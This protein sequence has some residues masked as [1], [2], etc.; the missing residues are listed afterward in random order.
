[1][2]S[3]RLRHGSLRLW[4]AW[5]LCG[6]ALSAAGP[7]CAPGTTDPPEE[8]TPIDCELG[9]W[10]ESTPFTSIA[11][12]GETPAEL[13]FGF[14]GFLW[15]DLSLRCPQPGP[16]VASVTLALA[17]DNERVFGSSLPRVEFDEFE[18][19]LV[20]GEMMMRLDNSEGPSA[21]A[22]L[23][24]DVT[25]RLEGDGYGGTAATAVVLVDD[26]KCIDTDEEP[27]CPDAGPTA[28]ADAGPDGGGA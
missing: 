2:S 28:L 3:C 26:D 11:D 8:L 9:L 19:D 17:T 10:T 4:G 12:D 14:Q 20:S 15:I 18:G 24:A 6:L 25:V 13:V 22:G 21:L 7:S 23:H 16:T 5:V 1:M 27:I